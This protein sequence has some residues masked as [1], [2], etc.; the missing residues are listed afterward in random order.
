M[1]RSEDEFGLSGVKLRGPDGSHPSRRDARR[2]YLVLSKKKAGKMRTT[3]VALCA[4]ALIAVAPAV[5]AQQISSKTPGQ[6]HKVL[7]KRPHVVGYV[8]WHTVH[9]QGA[10]I[11]YPGAFG[12][13]PSQPKDY[14]IENSRQ[15][16]G[17][18]GGGM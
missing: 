1:V 12:Y 13:A 8:P 14:T 16:G 6:Q 18:G 7:K 15:A 5:L 2:A 9:A 3:I 10:K 11:G 17:G 4:A